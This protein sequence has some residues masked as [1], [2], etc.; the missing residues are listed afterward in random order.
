M[1]M[2]FRAFGASSRS[3]FLL[4]LLP[5]AAKATPTENLGIRVLPAPGAVSVDGHLED[6]DLSGGI[7]ACD[8]VQTQ[9]DS[10]GVWFHAMYDSGNLYLLAH[11]LDAT[12]MNNPGQ[13]I[14]DYGFAGD[15][16]QLRTITG[17]DGPRERGQHFTAW[18]GQDGKDVIKVEQG[19]DFKEGVV[20]D[21]KSDQGA[22]QA[23]LKDP[24]GRGYVQEIAIPWKLLTRDGQ[25]LAAGDSFRLTIEPNFTVGTKGRFS[26]KDIF[27]SGLTPDRVFTFMSSQSWG[28][29]TLEPKGRVTPAA[30]RL[31]DAREF[32]VKLEAGALVADWD[33]LVQ[34]E[35][36]AGF[37]PLEFEMPF[38][39][40]VSLNISNGEHAVERQLLTCAP[41]SKGRHTVKWDGLSTWSWTRP[42]ELLPPGDYTWNAVAHTGLG[43]RLRG[44][45]ANS[46]KTPWDSDDGK[47]NW[48]GDHG[49][50]VAV[51]ADDSQV[52]LG[53][54]GAEAGK[55]VLAT[56]SDGHVLWSNNRAGICG[57]KSLAAAD[58]VVCV[59]GGSSG[60]D[61]D[62]G[63][64]YKLESRNGSYLPWDGRENADLQ[65]AAIWS[66]GDNEKPRKADSVSV[67]GRQIYLTFTKEKLVAVI[68]IRDG[69]LVKTLPLEQSPVLQA[70]PQ[71]YAADGL[72]FT[73]KGEPENQIVVRKEGREI[74]RIGRPGGRALLGP[75][76]ADGL[77]LVADMT[78]DAAGK[79]WVAE[80]DGWPKRVS[81]WDPVS[82][83]LLREFFGSTGYGALG[84]AIN[85]L[86]PDI[87]IG[88]GCEW[89]LDPQSGHAHCT[90]VVTRDGMENS[91]FAVGTNGKLYLA[92]AEKWAFESG[93]VRIFERTGE[94]QYRLR[95]AFRYDGR[96]PSAKTILW[97]DSNGDAQEQPDEVQVADGTLRFS[98]WFMNLGTDLT[99][100]AG[101]K[102]FQPTGFTACGAPVY[103]LRNPVKLSAP[104]LCSAD[105][106]LVLQPGNYGETHT[107]LNCYDALSGKQ[108]WSYPD[109][110]NGVHG[111]HNACP[112]VRGMIRGSYGICG[113]VKFPEPVG[114]LFV[115]PTNVGEWH[116]LTGSGFYLSK[117]FQGDPLKMKW[118]AEAVPGADVSQCPPGMGGEDFGGSI[119]L[120][121][122]GKLYLQAGK[123]AYW[124][125][126]VTGLESVT[127]LA[128]GKLSL[129]AQD[130]QVARTF[131]DGRLQ[132]AA[133]KKRLA[134]ARGAVVFTGNLETD[135]KGQE[136]AVFQKQEDTS[137]R[138]AAA[139][140]DASL[141][142]AWDV[143]DHTPW[144]NG[145]A[146][147]EFLYLGGDTV[148][149]QMGSDPS[150][151]P[152][153]EEAVEGDLRVSV[154]NY[155]GSPTVVVYRPVS[156]EK[157][158]KTFSSGVVKSYVVDYVQVLTDA[159]VKVR[160]HRDGYVVEAAI[161]LARLGLK[162][163]AQA[164][165]GDFGV[166]YGDTAGKRTRLRNYWSNQQTG[167]VDDAVFE[168]KLQP[169][170]W[171]GLDFR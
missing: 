76:Q 97:T 24:D 134:V 103:D 33:G 43:L 158:P 126:E 155:Q 164:L 94:G 151:D 22:Q 111:S 86:D 129:N 79:L 163:G 152:Q 38:D 15:S 56:D 29:A 118:P 166:T 84:G 27:K 60:A 171:G 70:V 57:V 75:W 85:P 104:G 123:T 83:K 159:V 18:H 72:N 149:F 127:G 7:F 102:K 142:L 58:G 42:G 36:I 17:A 3:L 96:G 71:A 47:G 110:F 73:W 112:P 41:Y 51:A 133:G 20:V 14:A 65:V 121:Q 169:G 46:G 108:L 19:K 138:T 109:N 28:V 64:L 105:G 39:G 23:F 114:N 137:V 147:P 52:Y 156:L 161:P 122:D 165:R 32:P 82:G 81:V 157:A 2:N 141:Y 95:C 78:L 145:A 115:I 153:R 136:I 131:R 26:I 88:Q 119:C 69:K 59:L 144:V 40:Y 113:A 68:G 128:G 167:L 53:W 1:N 150:A 92:V 132:A 99:I 10:M 124:N 162:A 170:N 49:V 48:G 13:T 117:L 120:G 62:G 154:G 50:P 61:A 45:A 140:D 116:L 25:G 93:P 30:V 9:R 168:L 89:R 87:M 5:M 21:A 44:W 100:S 54:N 74:R 67:S 12:P 90:G 35:E 107:A 37:K 130:I 146:A 139:S 8:D 55:S 101:D 80:A 135:F 160:T 143:Q 11:F 31:A 106:S 125:V 91:R 16:L 6:W 4:L 34:P 148:D 77:R 63:N 98:A 66:A